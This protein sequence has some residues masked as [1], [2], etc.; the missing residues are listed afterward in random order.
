M[1]YVYKLVFKKEDGRFY[2]L[3]GNKTKQ[4]VYYIGTTH[5]CKD[6]FV[7]STLKGARKY[8]NTWC[9]D[10]SYLPKILRCIP[11][12]SVT[13]HPKHGLTLACLNPIDR[14]PELRFVDRLTPVAEV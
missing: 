14:R 2:S 3:T 8:R 7:M 4:Q 11:E 13:K 5:S 9:V 6:M 1:R 12:E 10:E